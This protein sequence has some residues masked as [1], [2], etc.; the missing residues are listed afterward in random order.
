MMKPYV[1]FQLFGINFSIELKHQPKNGKKRKKGNYMNK[2][3]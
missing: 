1:I 2:M 3:Q